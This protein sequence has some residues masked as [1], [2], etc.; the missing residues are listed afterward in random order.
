MHAELLPE[1]LRFETQKKQSI[2]LC[3]YSTD[4]IRAYVDFVYME[5]IEFAMKYTYRG[6]TIYE[7]LNF[8]LYI[9]LP[10][11]KEICVK[12]IFDQASPENADDI[13]ASANQCGN[14]YLYD[15]HKRLI[16]SENGNQSRKV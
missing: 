1:K 14:K 10:R 7:L 11:L 13:I 8:S 5:P 12:I 6:S 4:T 15:L 9:N 2:T 16:G 3:N